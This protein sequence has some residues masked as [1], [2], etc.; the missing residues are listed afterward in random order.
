[1]TLEQ[2]EIAITEYLDGTLPPEKLPALEAILA[3]DENAQTLLKQ[4]RNLT[5]LLRSNPLP[6]MHWGELG[7]DFAAVV[8]GTVD[9][10]SRATDQKLNG[11]LK[12]IPAGPAIKWDA[13]ARHISASIDTELAAKD[14]DDEK[15]DALLHATPL[16]SLNWD[17]LASHISDQVAAQTAVV[18]KQREPKREPE[19]EVTV[20][21]MPWLR[22]V[23]RLAVAACVLLVAGLGIRFM[24]QRGTGSDQT[25]VGPKTATTPQAIVMVE[26][27]TVETA[28]PG[29]SQVAEVSIGPSNAYAVNSDEELY[30]RGVANRP[31]VVIAF[32]VT[33]IDDSDH[34]LG[35][36]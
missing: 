7:R 29:K 2:L 30:R 28:G 35:F 23:S 9:E 11:L 14:A 19:R 3:T 25:A 12:S 24:M 27:P 18:E 5:A 33:Q 1:M 21:R 6:E 15:L 22:T 13:L 10:Q 4:H 26:G 17:R 31:Q 32:P 34:A 16:P 8:T 20:Y 36:E